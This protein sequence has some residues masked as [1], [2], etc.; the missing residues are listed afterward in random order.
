MSRTALGIHSLSGKALVGAVLLHGVLWT[1]AGTPANAEE[2]RVFTDYA[3]VLKIDRPVAKVI[4]G[5]PEIADVAV[6]DA[7]TVVLTGRS[8]GTTNL[9][10]LDGEGR[11]LVD[12]KIVVSRNG[13]DTLRI[14]RNVEPTTLT[15]TP[16]CESAERAASMTGK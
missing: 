3:R 6:S 15:C 9:V 7:H 5:N 13:E 12:E 2:I 8:F 1:T 10:I 16:G 4:I 14:Y 11:A